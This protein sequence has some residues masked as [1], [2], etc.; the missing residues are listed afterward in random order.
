MLPIHISI[1]KHVEPSVFNLL[2]SSYPESTDVACDN[3]ERTPIEMA[4]ASSS[5]HKKY[6]LRAMKK[7]GALHSTIV[8]DPLSDLLC[9]IDY[10]EVI[11][12]SPF[13]Q[14]RA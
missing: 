4:K 2:V 8:T 9:G 7:G 13:I 10:R 1:K 6:Y 14:M 5:A 11:R 12:S 3:D